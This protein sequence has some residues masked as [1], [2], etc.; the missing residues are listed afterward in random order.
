MSQ[1]K[2]I[3][4]I[5]HPG[6]GKGLLAKILAEKLGWSFVDMDFGLEFLIGRSLEE[7]LGK[8]GES[9]FH[10]TECNI[11]SVLSRKENIVVTTDAAIT[12][13]EAACKLLSNEFVVYLKVST[14]TQLERN[15]RNA[16]P[17]IPVDIKEFLNKLHEK[18]DSKYQQLAKFSIDSDDGDLDTHVMSVI[19]AGKLDN[20]FKLASDKINL[21]KSDYVV[22][23]RKTH[24][25]IELPQH[26]AICL[27][28]LSQGKSSKEIANDLEISHRTVEGYIEKMMK[29]LGCETSK[30]LLALYH[31]KP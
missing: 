27:K 26:Q 4:I 12:D 24:R 31:G 28:L 22:F 1:H 11:F 5:G 8:E 15:V 3:F 10:R 20:E 14:P 25:P 18:R 17:L 29:K 30:E 21:D 2:R 19:K 16:E 7:I 23:H 6:A 9:A 13:S